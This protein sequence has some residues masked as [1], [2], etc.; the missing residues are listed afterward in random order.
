MRMRTTLLVA[1]SL[2]ALLAAAAPVAAFGPTSG[3]FSDCEV[4]AQNTV[5]WGL[6]K[7]DC[8]V[9]TYSTLLFGALNRCVDL[10]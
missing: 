5:C 1:A 7:E 8:E 2:V 10:D 4:V 9:K 6:L 3:D